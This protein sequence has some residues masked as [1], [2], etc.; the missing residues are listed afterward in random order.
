MLTVVYD[1]EEKTI[2]IS[3]YLPP[4]QRG[5]EKGVWKLDK[6]DHL[7]AGQEEAEGERL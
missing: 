5:E 4:H 7:E 6:P 2:P 1:A 3:S